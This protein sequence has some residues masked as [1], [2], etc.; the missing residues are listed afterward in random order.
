[1]CSF[2]LWFMVDAMIETMLETMRR[3]LIWF[4]IEEGRMPGQNDFVRVFF[5]FCILQELDFNLKRFNREN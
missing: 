5:P 2:G 1:M 4:L 3:E